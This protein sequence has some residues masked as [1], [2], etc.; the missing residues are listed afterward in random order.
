[1]KKG[2]GREN[3]PTPFS[4][5]KQAKSRTNNS[6]TKE[7]RLGGPLSL[8]WPGE[9]KMREQQQTSTD[10][11]GGTILENEVVPAPSTTEK[12]RKNKKDQENSGKRRPKNGGKLNFHKK[13][14]NNIPHGGGDS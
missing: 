2:I 7:R 4:Q 5:E 6:A 14:I 10:K 11:R 13:T 12:T 8:G 3:H 9:K 1:L